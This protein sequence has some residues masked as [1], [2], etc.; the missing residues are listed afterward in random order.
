MNT[1]S[2]LFGWVICQFHG[3]KHKPVDA[4]PGSSNWD[5]TATPQKCERCGKK[6]PHRYS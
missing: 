2:K 3:G 4:G 5:Y 6:L 1:L